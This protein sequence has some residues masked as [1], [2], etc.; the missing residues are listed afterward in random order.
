MARHDIFFSFA[1]RIIM[2]RLV[3]FCLIFSV[4]FCFGY[5]EA[6]S[7]LS[8]F[9]Y[10]K[11]DDI[12]PS[13]LWLKTEDFR[14]QMQA[15]HDLGF[16]PI[17][18]KDLADYLDYSIPFPANPVI[19]T[20]DDAYENFYTKAFPILQEYG[21]KAVVY[22]I[23]GYIGQQNYWDQAIEPPTMH[24]N[25]DM[26]R[27]ISNAGIEIGCH[28]ISHPHLASIP[29]E[30]A[31]WEI[32]GAEKLIEKKLGKNISSFSYPFG[33]YN[34]SVVQYCK[35][36]NVRTAVSTIAGTNDLQYLD[37]FLIKRINVRRDTTIEDFKAYLLGT[38]GQLLTHENQESSPYSIRTMSI[39][40]HPRPRVYA[41]VLKNGNWT[42]IETLW[43]IENGIHDF[44]FILYNQ[45]ENSFL[46]KGGIHIHMDCPGL[47]LSYFNEDFDDAL[48]F[49]ENGSHPVDLSNAIG[50]EFTKINLL[51]DH[52][53]GDQSFWSQVSIELFS[54]R[55]LSYR[56]WITDSD[57][58]II[59]PTYGQL[60]G[61]T[62]EKTSY[63]TRDPDTA[64]DPFGN[65][66]HYH[67]YTCDPTD[68]ISRYAYYLKDII[69]PVYFYADRSPYGNENL[70]IEDTEITSFA[71]AWLTGEDDSIE[72]WQVSLG[73]EIFLKGGGY[74]WNGDIWIPNNNY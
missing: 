40:N 27:E 68:F 65:P 17:T 57:D 47:I 19:L 52:E 43:N 21:F 58:T 37:R 53:L 45:G 13:S 50:I 11:I 31:K 1:P 44:A 5:C 70:S 61:P 41:A 10:H 34:D 15:I 20:V 4:I 16:H 46:Q 55:K 26:I 6:N 60:C 66:Y 54:N 18:L 12:T 42:P 23:E 32:F 69:L 59:N 39:G 8:V 28:T 38:K 71:A 64:L 67:W 33:S 29:F 2:P 30:K 74:F 36:I 72:D 24:M 56:G 7:N 35:D 62:N 22:V 49:D 73:G 51:N 48:T 9:M 3:L 25:W 14:A 63:I